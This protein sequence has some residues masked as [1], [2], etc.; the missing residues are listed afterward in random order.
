MAVYEFEGARPKRPESGSGWIADNAAVIG[1]VELGEDVTVWFNAVLRGDNEPIVI[2]DR[3]NIQEGVTIHTDLGFPCTV[4]AGCTIG[5]NAILHGCVI[6]DGSLV[7]MGAT[8]LNGARIGRGCIV[9]A[10]ALVPENKQFPDFSLIVGVPA[11]VVRTFDPDIVTRLKRSSDSYVAK[12]ARFATSLK[13][14]D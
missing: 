5:H 4:G 14:I 3:S 13:R 9:G 7:G 10:N 1:K 12:G 6:E 11:K 2:G 8:I